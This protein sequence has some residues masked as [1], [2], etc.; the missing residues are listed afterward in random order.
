LA[1][2]LLA[3]GCSSSP[4]VS[5]GDWSDAAVTSGGGYYSWTGSLRFNNT[6]LGVYADQ[7]A[8]CTPYMTIILTG[9]ALPVA[10]GQEG[11]INLRVDGGK[12]HTIKASNYPDA[13]G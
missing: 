2:A 10:D 3:T 1:L 6:A 8:D 7:S 13:L 5:A 4:T 9:D 11:N 12:I